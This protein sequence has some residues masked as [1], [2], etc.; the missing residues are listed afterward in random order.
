MH[1]EMPKILIYRPVSIFPRSG[2]PISNIVGRQLAQ[3][4]LVVEQTNFPSEGRA[5]QANPK[6]IPPNPLAK[7]YTVP[8]ELDTMVNDK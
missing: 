1:V 4:L 8:A 7:L 5:R 6:I 2:Q 3:L